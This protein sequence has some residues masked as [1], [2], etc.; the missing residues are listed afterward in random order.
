LQ[1][2]IL[3]NL[4]APGLK[5]IKMVKLY[6]KWRQFVPEPFQDE[7]CPKPPDGILARIKKDHS[8]KAKA[9]KKT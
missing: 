8:D 4:L 9:K 5:K 1:A 6:M 2:Y 7:I 3:N